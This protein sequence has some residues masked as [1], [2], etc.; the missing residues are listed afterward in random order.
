MVD[1][2]GPQEVSLK[3]AQALRDIEELSESAIE[4]WAN[5]CE[6]DQAMSQ[7]QA[8]GLRPALPAC[9]LIGSGISISGRAGICEKSMAHSL[10]Q[11][12]MPIREGERPH[13]TVPRH[14]TIGQHNREKRAH[15]A[16]DGIIDRAMLSE[17]E[18][19]KTKTV[20]PS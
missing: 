15:L 2:I 3:P 11:P 10:A 16:R 4:A 6:A 9:Q 5:S 17:E 1:Q 19:T 7:L 14:P 13:V 18:L 20:S 8:A 12:S